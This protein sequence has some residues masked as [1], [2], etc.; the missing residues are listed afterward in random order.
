VIIV[1]GRTGSDRNIG[2]VTYRCH[3]GNSTIDYCIISPDIIPFIQDFQV[4][5]LD[6][7]LSDK[8]S[9][10]VLTLKTKNYEIPKKE[11]IIYKETDIN[12]EQINSKW[13]EEKNPI[14][15]QTLIKIK[16]VIYYY[17]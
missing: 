13:N 10:I 3:N 8:H 17:C 4:D 14:S 2:D 12:Y 15:N 6:K 16:S 7:N 5:I 9:P 1:N 11:N